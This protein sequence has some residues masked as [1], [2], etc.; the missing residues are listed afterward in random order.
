MANLPY[1][2]FHSSAEPNAAEGEFMSNADIGC[3]R[4]GATSARCCR[5]VK[6]CIIPYAINA[7]IYGQNKIFVSR[8]FENIEF[9]L[10]KFEGTR[11][12]KSNLRTFKVFENMCEPCT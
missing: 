3:L 4:F 2:G 5:T 11:T 6:K 1:T 12:D 9:N 8:T 7:N 10:R